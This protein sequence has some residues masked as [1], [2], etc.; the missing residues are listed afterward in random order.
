[1]IKRKYNYNDAKKL[2][3]DANNFVNF[4][5]HA[6]RCGTVLKGKIKENARSF[7]LNETLT[8]LKGILL[9]ELNKG[10]SRK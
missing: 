5:S 7:L 3:K 6:S 8:I 9:E 10:E 2:L 4:H 1:V